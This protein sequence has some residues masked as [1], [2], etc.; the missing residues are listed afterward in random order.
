MLHWFRLR[1]SLI[2]SL[3]VAGLVTAGGAAIVPHQDDCHDGPCAFVQHD[4]S[5]HRIT[6]PTGDSADPL[7]CLACHWARA[8]RLRTEAR[9]LPAPVVKTGEIVHFEYFPVPAAATAGQ[10]PLR[11]PPSSSGLS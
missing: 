8:F 4:P 3:A 1:A 9:T 2:A 7:H 11:S 5:A 6:A 10:P